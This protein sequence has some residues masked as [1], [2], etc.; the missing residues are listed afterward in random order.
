MPLDLRHFGWDDDVTPTTYPLS[1]PD[2]DELLDFCE[3]S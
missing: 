3:M 2:A 1:A